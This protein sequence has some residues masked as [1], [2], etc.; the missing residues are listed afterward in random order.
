MLCPLCTE[1]DIFESYGNSQLQKYIFKLNKTSEIKIF[2]RNTYF[3]AH[4]DAP[5]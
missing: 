3:F 4:S 1:N 5:S 2:S